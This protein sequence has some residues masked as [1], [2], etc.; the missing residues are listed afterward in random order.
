VLVA[1]LQRAARAPQPQLAANAPA[2]AEQ[3]RL[4]A[5]DRDVHHQGA[6]GREH[7][8]GFGQVAG[9]HVDVFQVLEHVHREDRV[10]RRVRQRHLGAVD[11]VE[12]GVVRGRGRAR[13]LDHVGGHVDRV[14]ALEL[15]R[16]HARDAPGAAADLENAVAELARVM[17]P[18]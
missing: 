16:Q 8:E 14:H 15:A 2:A 17:G 12:R 9:H 6:A 18:L 5:R 3:W 1:V 11:L 7:A 13:L 10:D 4:L